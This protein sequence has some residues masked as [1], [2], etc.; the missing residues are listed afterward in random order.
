MIDS[1]L[2]EFGQPQSHLATLLETCTRNFLQE[3]GVRDC[4]DICKA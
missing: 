2:T 4:K 3:Q 1:E